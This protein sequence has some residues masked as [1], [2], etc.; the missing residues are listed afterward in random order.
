MQQTVESVQLR[1]QR[2]VV[3]QVP[4]DK[5]LRELVAIFHHLRAYYVR[6]YLC[7][8]DSLALIEFLARYR[9]FPQWVFGVTA[10]PFNAH[11]WVQEQDCVLNDTVE[12]VRGFTPIMAI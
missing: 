9:H 7:L 5:A 10:E 8:F 1:N 2:R 11:C 6:K 4:D 12:Y 3:S